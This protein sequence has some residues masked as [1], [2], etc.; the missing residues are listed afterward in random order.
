MAS[1]ISF[2]KADVIVEWLSGFRMTD[3]QSSTSCSNAVVK[4]VQAPRPGAFACAS[5]KLDPPVFSM[6]SSSRAPLARKDDETVQVAKG[7]SRDSKKVDRDKLLVV[8]AKERLPSLRGRTGY[9]DPVFGNGGVCNVE[10]KQIEFRLDARRAHSE[11]SRDI[12]RM[13]SRISTPIFGRPGEV[14]F[15]F[16]RQKS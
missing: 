2:L 11:F 3:R 10:P 15:V 6:S 8:I 4:F 14:T 9:F 7:G 12:L 16:H 13:R 5:P 1:S